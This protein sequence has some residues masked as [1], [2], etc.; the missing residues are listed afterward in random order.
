MSPLHFLVVNFDARY[1]FGC[2]ISDPC[3]LEARN[4][5]GV[6]P[7]CHVHCEYLWNLKLSRLSSCYRIV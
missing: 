2:K 1:Y 4:M 5:K 3:L 7:I 6:R